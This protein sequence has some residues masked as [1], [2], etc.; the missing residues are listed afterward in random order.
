MLMPT[1]QRAKVGVNGILAKGSAKRYKSAT[2]EL[3]ENLTK[4]CELF[5]EG[6]IESDFGT[7]WN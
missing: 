1:A 2:F 7:C 5:A 3:H 4:V 6:C